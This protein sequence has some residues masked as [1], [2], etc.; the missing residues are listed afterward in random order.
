MQLICDVGEDILARVVAFSSSLVD[1]GLP[2]PLVKPE[3]RAAREML[4]RQWPA[5]ELS[6]DVHDRGG[7]MASE[8]FSREVLGIDAALR[9][10]VGVMEDV[11]EFV[12]AAAGVIAR[13]APHA[14]RVGLGPLRDIVGAAGAAVGAGGG[15]GSAGDGIG[16]QNAGLLASWL[17]ACC[18]VLRVHVV[19]A[20]RLGADARTA[21]AMFAAATHW[22]SKTE[23]S[24]LGSTARIAA[25]CA[26]QA[27]AVAAAQV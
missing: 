4:L 12:E 20:A 26:S 25:A 10:Y 1:N 3:L 23:Y 19:T 7:A 24:A 8:A 16:A 21:V 14:E 6:F 17:E 13:A 9:E 15:G 5:C 18:T 11:A 22:V 27:A 2:A